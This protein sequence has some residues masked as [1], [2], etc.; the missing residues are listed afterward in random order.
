MATRPSLL[1]ARSRRHGQ[2]RKCC[3]P[4]LPA[5]PMENGKYGGDFSGGGGLRPPNFRRSQSGRVEPENESGQ[6]TKV[7]VT[8]LDFRPGGPL[9][10]VDRAEAVI[11]AAAA[12]R[13]QC[14]LQF[15]IGGRSM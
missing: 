5:A 3:A 11:D 9:W 15:S 8:A 10:G 14:I 7:R 1:G 6:G 13:R 2:W 12:G 4:G